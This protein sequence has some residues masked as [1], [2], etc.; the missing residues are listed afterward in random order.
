MRS[1]RAA[2]PLEASARAA[3]SSRCGCVRNQNPAPPTALRATAAA[4]SFLPSPM[5]PASILLDAEI[6]VAGPAVLADLAHR[7]LKRG[8]IGRRRCRHGR[9]I[10]LVLVGCCLEARHVLPDFRRSG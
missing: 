1:P 7:R 8:Q 3:S 6:L 5:R 9:Y 2:S 10:G 4:R